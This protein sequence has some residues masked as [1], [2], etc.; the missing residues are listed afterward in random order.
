MFLFCGTLTA[1]KIFTTGIPSSIYMVPLSV[2][3]GDFNNDGAFDVAVTGQN[4]LD[5]SG[6]LSILYGRGDGGF[7]NKIDL[8]TDKYAVDV[9]AVDLDNDGLLDLVTANKDA[10][11]LNIFMNQKSGG[12]KTKD[13]I[14]VKGEPRF[15]SS[16]DFNKDGRL[17]LVVVVG[18]ELHFFKGSNY[19]YTGSISLESTPVAI[20]AGDFSGSG[21][22]H[23]L[24]RFADNASVDL[25]APNDLSSKMTAGIIKLDMSTTPYFAR[26]GYINE[27]DF[28]DA[29]RLGAGGKSVIAQLSSA[30]GLLLTE[31]EVIPVEQGTNDFV[32]GDFNKD[33]KD[34]IG[35]MDPANLQILI[36]LNESPGSPVNKN[37]SDMKMAVLYDADFEKPNTV[38]MGMLAAYKNASMIIYDPSG[39]ATRTYFEFDADLPEGQ[40]FALEWNGTDANDAKV[41]DGTYVFYYRL[42][43][44]VV[45]RILKK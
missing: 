17:D 3:V 37:T 27:D 12:F 38:N 11:T 19:K 1:Q 16:G 34:D 30:N 32:V 44:I 15:V 7:K 43:S 6:Q 26:L 2:A 28:P 33:G 25:V 10:Q 8:L 35:V 36:Y 21:I 40:Q 24:V 39:N 9:H 31:Q 23:V 29:V 5:G 20:R 41:P 14:K 45:A 22:S 42:G 13:P 4:D 18:N